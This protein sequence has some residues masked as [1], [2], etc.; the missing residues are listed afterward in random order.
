MFDNS[1]KIGPMEQS[2]DRGSKKTRCC[3]DDEEQTILSEPLLESIDPQLPVIARQG[4]GEVNHRLVLRHQIH[5]NNASAKSDV[6]LENLCGGS[7]KYSVVAARA[8]E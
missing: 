2:G 5:G 6:E 4:R 3:D 1:G 8:S 7:V